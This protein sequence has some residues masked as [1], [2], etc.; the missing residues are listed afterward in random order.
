MHQ[1]YTGPNECGIKDEEDAIINIPH[2][3]PEMGKCGNR[4]IHLPLVT[5]EQLPAIKPV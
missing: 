4:D 2:M 3:D 5:Y 1:C